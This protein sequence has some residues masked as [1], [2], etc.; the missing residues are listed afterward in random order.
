MI[1][2]ASVAVVVVCVGGGGLGWDWLSM[3]R[4]SQPVATRL[5]QRAVGNRKRENQIYPSKMRR[6]AHGLSN[7]TRS[8]KKSTKRQEYF[9]HCIAY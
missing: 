8:S 4:L 5:E 6:R 3:D 7:G 2:P 1:S 9:T